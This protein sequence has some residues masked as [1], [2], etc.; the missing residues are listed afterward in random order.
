MFMEACR[1]L[2][3]LD[4]SSN[5]I[6]SFPKQFTLNGMTQLRVLLIHGNKFTKFNDL[7]VI[8]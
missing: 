5:N 7:K 2:L 3:R 4:I 8:L 1:N 6:S